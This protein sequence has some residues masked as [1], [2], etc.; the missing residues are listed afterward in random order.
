MTNPDTMTDALHSILHWC[1]AY[2]VE[3]FPEP[4]LD[5]IRAQIGDGAFSALHAAW[6]RHIVAGVERHARAGLGL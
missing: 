4:D 3:I 6:A 1:R 2:P 5:A